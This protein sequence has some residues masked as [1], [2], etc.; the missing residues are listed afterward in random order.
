MRDDDDRAVLLDGVDACLDLFGGNGI[1]TGGRLVEEDDRWILEEHAGNGDALLLTARKLLCPRL[2]SVGQFHDLVVDV[3]LFGWEL[4]D[5]EDLQF[6]PELNRKNYEHFEKELESGSTSVWFV[7]KEV[8]DMMDKS[9][10]MPVQDILG[11]IP[12]KGLVDE[13]AIDCSSLSFSHDMTRAVTYNTYLVLRVG[14]S[15]SFIMGEDIAAQELEES[16]ALYK[17]IVEYKK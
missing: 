3:C 9:I 11:Y 1:Q 7:S 5:G 4:K 6:H 17:A 14:R 12:E 8:Y 10:L 13:Y 2:E 16:L 15:Y